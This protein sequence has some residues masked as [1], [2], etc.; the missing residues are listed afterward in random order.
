[1]KKILLFSIL[2]FL[3]ACSGVK[4]TSEALNT[5]NYVSP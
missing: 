1:M 2:A 5:G 4:K 3:I